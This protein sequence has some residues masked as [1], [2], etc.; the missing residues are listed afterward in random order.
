MNNVCIGKSKIKACIESVVVRRRSN[1][2]RIS[3]AWKSVEKQTPWRQ[4]RFSAPAKAKKTRN[5]KGTTASN[6]RPKNDAS[7]GR[8]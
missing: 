7:R 6:T 1:H 3:E 8:K 5:A 2:Q 4:E